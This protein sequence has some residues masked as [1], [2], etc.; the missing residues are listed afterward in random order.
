MTVYAGDEIATDDTAFGGDWDCQ[1][2]YPFCCDCS[3][4]C[5]VCGSRSEG[6]PNWCGC[7]L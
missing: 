5:T 7:E 1:D 3:Y 6:S 4:E 2:C